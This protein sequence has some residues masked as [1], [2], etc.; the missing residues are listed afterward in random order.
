MHGDSAQYNLADKKD[1]NMPDTAI[2]GGLKKFRLLLV[3]DCGHELL[4]MFKLQTQ[5]PKAEELR[6]AASVRD[7]CTSQWSVAPSN[8]GNKSQAGT[9]CML[10]ARTSFES[11]DGTYT[12]NPII[13]KT[14]TTIPTWYEFRNKSS[15]SSPVGVSMKNVGITSL[16][17]VTL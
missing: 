17:M 7:A 6:M 4:A 11:R 2:L 12:A 1:A 3:H 14:T 9:L 15:L 5:C 16:Y 8:A 13:A 10:R